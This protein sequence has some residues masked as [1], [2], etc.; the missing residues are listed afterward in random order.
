MDCFVLET[1]ATE[2]KCRIDTGL[3]KTGGNTDLMIVF[4]KASEEAVCE[5]RTTCEFTWTAH[6]PDVTSVNLE[7]SGSEW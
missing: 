5:P 4:L 3:E 1:G 6:V 2:I 7:F